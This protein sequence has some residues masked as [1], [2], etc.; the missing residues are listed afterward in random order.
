[1]VDD[2]HVM[3]WAGRFISWYSRVGI[4]TARF[5]CSVLTF[6]ICCEWGGS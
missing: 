6:E 3:I 1:M 5:V 2:E 4:Q